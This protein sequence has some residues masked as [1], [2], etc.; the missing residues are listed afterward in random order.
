MIVSK[1]QSK[2]PFEDTHVMY[3]ITLGHLTDDRCFLVF[4]ALNQGKCLLYCG[5]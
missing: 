4:A 1:K 2:N 5:C 3:Q